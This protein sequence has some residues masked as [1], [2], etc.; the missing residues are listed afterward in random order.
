MLLLTNNKPVGAIR[1]KHLILK[2]A[3]ADKR[4]ETALVIETF[5]GAVPAQA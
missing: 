5:G 1:V 2:K 3:I 4:A